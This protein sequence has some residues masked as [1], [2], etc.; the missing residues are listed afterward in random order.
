MSAA[1]AIAQLPRSTVPPTPDGA[2][3][4]EAAGPISPLGPLPPVLAFAENLCSDA[5][6][7]RGLPWPLCYPDVWPAR[8]PT[9]RCYGV[10]R[11]PM[12]VTMSG[13]PIY[14]NSSSR[15]QALLM[16]PWCKNITLLDPAPYQSRPRRDARFERPTRQAQFVASHYHTRGRRLFLET[17]LE[18]R[19]RNP[20]DD[21]TVE[22]LVPMQSWRAG[23]E[24][25]LGASRRL[26]KRP[27]A[28]QVTK[29]NTG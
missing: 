19:H 11:L 1:A 5:A 10:D 7:D 20:S 15:S 8:G 2:V 27:R 22:A 13:S 18:S 6:R 23:L 29:R 24:S 12:F 14:S 21:T 25:A 17:S 9:V 3:A 26:Q 16:P 4:D 28:P